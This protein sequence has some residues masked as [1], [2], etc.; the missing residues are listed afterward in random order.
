MLRFKDGSKHTYKSK[1]TLVN[2]DFSILIIV[3]SKPFEIYL[4]PNICSISPNQQWRSSQWNPSGLRYCLH[5]LKVGML[6]FMAKLCHN[7]VAHNYLWLGFFGRF[8]L[9]LI[10]H[11]APVFDMF[12]WQNNEIEVYPYSP[13]PLTSTDPPVGV[14]RG[15]T[16]P[17]RW[18]AALQ[19][20]GFSLG[21][22]GTSESFITFSLFFVKF[23]LSDYS[24]CNQD[25]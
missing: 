18:P 6:L 9:H 1:N 8:F 25:Y 7:K 2:N 15:N 12:G 17:E 19:K 24:K 21:S 3:S 23:H 13:C 22:A 16:K 14:P 11:T 20:R 4:D 10:C 5:S